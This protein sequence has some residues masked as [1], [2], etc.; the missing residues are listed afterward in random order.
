MLRRSVRLAAADGTV[1]A[2]RDEFPIGPL[3]PPTTWAA[4]DE[5]PGYM[6]LPIPPGTPPGEYRLLVGLY[7]PNTLA[8]IGELVEAARLRLAE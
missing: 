3:L 4:G 5:K 7:D 8:P 1:A 6:A 2:Q